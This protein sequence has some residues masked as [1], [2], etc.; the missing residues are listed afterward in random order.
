MTTPAPVKTIRI[1]SSK[2][3]TIKFSCHDEL[4]LPPG[5]PQASSSLGA[6]VD[7]VVV[8]RAAPAGVG[9]PL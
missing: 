1:T 2:S 8:E 6:H 5:G 4:M 3:P 9:E 7:P